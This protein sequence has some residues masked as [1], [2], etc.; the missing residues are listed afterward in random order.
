LS[1]MVI[2]FYSIE[3]H[4]CLAPPAGVVAGEH[5]GMKAICVAVR[6]QLGLL[7]CYC[8]SIVHSFGQWATVNCDLLLLLLNCKPLLLCVVDVWRTCIDC[9]IN[10]RYQH[11]NTLNRLHHHWTLTWLKLLPMILVLSLMMMMMMMMMPSWTVINSVHIVAISYS[12]Y[13]FTD[14]TLSVGQQ[15]QRPS[16]ENLTN[17]VGDNFGSCGP[18]QRIGLF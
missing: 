2:T 1:S 6:A 10:R 17:L 9:A 7:S 3:Y 11:L 4:H 18:M 12:S 16:T 13:L 14:Q 5:C 15:D 8:A